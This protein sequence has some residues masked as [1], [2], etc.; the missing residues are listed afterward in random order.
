MVPRGTVGLGYWPCRLDAESDRFGNGLECS[1]MA[2][3]TRFPVVGEG[4]VFGS[5]HAARHEAPMSGRGR[6][7]P[8]GTLRGKAQPG[9][10]ETAYFVEE[11]G[12]GR[13][14]AVA[15]I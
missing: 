8:V 9:R 4:Q 10:R 11:L 15:S 12:F 6:K 3:R 7:P 2:N 1:L 14:L 13:L 5:S